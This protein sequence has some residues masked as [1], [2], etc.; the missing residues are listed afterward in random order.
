MKDFS[1]TYLTSDGQGKR[2]ILYCD[3]LVTK[4]QYGEVSMRKK[5]EWITTG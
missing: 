3:L 1:S 2:K 5:V 4:Y